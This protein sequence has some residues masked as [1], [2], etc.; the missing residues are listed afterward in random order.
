VLHDR[1]PR[2]A[3]RRLARARARVRRTSA[4]F[5][6]LPDFLIVGAQRG[7]TSS[8]YKYLGAHPNVIPS[9]R[10]E[11]EY[12]SFDYSKGE[13]WYRGHFPL[14]VRMDATRAIR[15]IAPRTFEA[16]PGYLLDPRA[17]KRAAAA[18]PHARLIAL[19]RNPVDRALSHYHHNRRLNHEPYGLEDALL[20][21]EG[22]LAGEIDRMLEDPSYPARSL[23]RFSYVERGMYADQLRGWL[24]HFTKSQLLVIRSEDLYANSASTFDTIL[25]FLELPNWRPPEFRN[26][27]LGVTAPKSV[28]MPADTRQR[29]LA[30]FQGPN[31]ELEHLLGRSMEWD[32]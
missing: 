17:P 7:G 16:S 21:E 26:F 13:D 6:S 32:S 8:L 24:E 29:L 25:Q 5:R 18:I 19:L 28:S 22:R 20:A 11:I 14:T 2:R 1:V 27:S 12:F 23:R 10:K 15:G 3:R 31:Q 9:L 30:L 4:V